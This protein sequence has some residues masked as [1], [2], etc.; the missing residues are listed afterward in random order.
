L[1]I[2][3]EL[4]CLDR[5]VFYPFVIRTSDEDVRSNPAIRGPI[6]ANPP[7]INQ[8]FFVNDEAGDIPNAGR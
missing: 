1:T 5:E 6:P 8:R 4:E 3:L 7:S 2:D